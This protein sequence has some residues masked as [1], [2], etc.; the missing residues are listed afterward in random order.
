MLALP[1]LRNRPGGGRPA[2]AGLHCFHSGIKKFLLHPQVKRVFFEPLWNQ[3]LVLCAAVKSRIQ[4]LVNDD[5]RG[6]RIACR[7]FPLSKFRNSF[8]LF[9]GHQHGGT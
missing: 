3:E 9:R 7:G 4:V 6:L 1:G 8:E 2:S 5:L